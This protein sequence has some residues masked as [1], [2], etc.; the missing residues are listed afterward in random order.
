MTHT[1][2]KE[3]IA[4]TQTHLRIAEIRD[5]IMILKNGGLRAIFKT[6]SINFNLKSEAEQN[7]IIYSYQSFL[8]TLEFPIQIVI[9]SRKL[10]ID[11]YIDNLKKLGEKQKNSLLKKQTFEY[12]EYIQKLIEYA[13]IMEKE[14][15][16][17]VP[18]DPYRAQKMNLF[19]K[20][21]AWMRPQDTTAEI[22]RRHSE[23]EEL[24]K[25]LSQRINIAKSALEQCGL[26]VE[27]LT[28]QKLIE[29]F[30]KIYNPDSSRFEKVEDAEKFDIVKD[31]E[32]SE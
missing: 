27:Q 24:R 11:H 26:K 12:A 1:T 23:H 2:K 19:Q 20:F 28:T 25:G 6:S 32:I 15:L 31:E 29:L 10:D 22:R 13:N 8:N 4:S 5:N 18:Y 9:R 21:L 7:S 3:Q 14:F 30:Y 16:V 17:V